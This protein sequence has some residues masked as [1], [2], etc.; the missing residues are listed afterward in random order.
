MVAPPMPTNGAT[1][2]CGK[3]CSTGTIRRAPYVAVPDPNFGSRYAIPPESAYVA[4]IGDHETAAPYELRSLP[5]PKSAPTV[6]PRFVNAFCSTGA[7]S[8]CARP[9]LTRASENATTIPAT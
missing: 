3:R 1:P 8:I 2:N 4:D 7:P 9:V 6:T 5:E